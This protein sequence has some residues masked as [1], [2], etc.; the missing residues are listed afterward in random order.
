[1][2][3]GIGILFR[4]FIIICAVLGINSILSYVLIDDVDDEVRYAMHELYEQE[5]IETLFLGSSHVFCGYDPQ[6]LDEIMGENTYLA[7]T[8]SAKN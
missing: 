7:A 3:R 2:K 5:N 4:G 6:I 8:P 1:M